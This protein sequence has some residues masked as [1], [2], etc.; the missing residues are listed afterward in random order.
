MDPGADFSPP[1]PQSDKET[2]ANVLWPEWRMTKNLRNTDLKQE[3][4]SHK[5]G[6]NEEKY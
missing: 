6:A 5:H 3:N 4:K 1:P 2:P